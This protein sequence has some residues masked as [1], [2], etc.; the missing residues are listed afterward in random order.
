M[1]CDR[2][3]P[4]RNSLNDGESDLTLPST[5]ARIIAHFILFLRDLSGKI[6]SIVKNELP[7]GIKDPPP[8]NRATSPAFSIIF[9]MRK[10]GANCG[11]FIIPLSR[12][13]SEIPARL[14]H[15][16]E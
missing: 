13:K 6:P 1:E 2:F 15:F 4:L 8:K 14:I 16:R 5:L 11:G 7:R 3:L 10:A 9:Q 12:E